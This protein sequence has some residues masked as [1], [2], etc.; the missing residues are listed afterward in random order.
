V[1]A[2][3]RS[4]GFG[5]VMF[6]VYYEDGTVAFSYA[7]EIDPSG[8][9]VPGINKQG[10]LK[11]KG[12]VAIVQDDLDVGW[13]II[14]GYE[15]YVYRM[16]MWIG[17][18]FWGVLDYLEEVGAIK[19]TGEKLDMIRL[20]KIAVANNVL[21]GIV[22]PKSKQEEIFAQ[23]HA[24]RNMAVKSGWTEQERVIA[25]RAPRGKRNASQKWEL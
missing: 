20:K 8:N 11:H 23:I 2:K 6:K 13:T 4:G 10:T 24:D 22:L 5:V 14:T 16:R 9:K 25:V 18:D 12:V 19:L 21:S 15:Y 3:T 17:T 1:S 7:T